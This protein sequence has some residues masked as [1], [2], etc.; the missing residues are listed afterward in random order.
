MV[1]STDR[2][3]VANRGT[4][5]SAHYNFV[6]YSIANLT[7]RPITFAESKCSATSSRAARQWAS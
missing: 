4:N 3:A 7:N 5:G 2:D 1:H 6:A